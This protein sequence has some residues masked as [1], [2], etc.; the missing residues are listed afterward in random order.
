MGVC[1]FQNVYHCTSISGVTSV[2]SSTLVP[3]KNN[4]VKL[5]L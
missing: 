4:T 1:G 2:G 3:V 5:F